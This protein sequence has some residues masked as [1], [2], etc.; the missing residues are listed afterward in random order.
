[1]VVD[2]GLGEWRDCG[3]HDCWRG[4][5]VHSS[6]MIRF[7]AIIKDGGITISVMTGRPR[8]SFLL[9]GSQSKVFRE[10]MEFRDANKAAKLRVKGDK[11]TNITSS[12]GIWKMKTV[13][14]GGM[15][16]TFELE[17]GKGDVVE[18]LA[19]SSQALELLIVEVEED[20]KYESFGRNANKTTT[21]TTKKRTIPN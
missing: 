1:V 12:A 6:T 3:L 4:Y 13:V 10:L 8:I 19:K 5:S 7:S 21:W 17:N 11:G 18:A 14:G 9:D 15:E 20:D 2:Y 16:F